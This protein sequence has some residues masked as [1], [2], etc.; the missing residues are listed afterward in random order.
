MHMVNAQVKPRATPCPGVPRP[1]RLCSFAGDGKAGSR[2]RLCRVRGRRQQLSRSGMECDLPRFPAFGHL[3]SKDPARFRKPPILEGEL[4]EFL[5]RV[6][7]TSQFRL[8]SCD[9]LL[10]R[11]VPCGEPLVGPAFSELD[12][13]PAEGPA[14]RNVNVEP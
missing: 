11:N 2:F 5:R 13:E 9:R 1:A 12:G 4:D 8:R 3:K 10:R 14:L 6:T 7:Q